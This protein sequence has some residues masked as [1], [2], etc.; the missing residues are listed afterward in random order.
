MGA[1]GQ[2]P[3]QQQAQFLGFAAG[4]EDAPDLEQQRPLA[5]GAVLGGFEQTGIQG[6]AQAGALRRQRIL[7]L[8]AGGLA[9]G[10]LG[11]GITGE[12]V[13]HHFLSAQPGQCALETAPR[14]ADG[15]R[16]VVVGVGA[17]GGQRFGQLGV[18]VQAGDF[19][20]QILPDH[21][22]HPPARRRDAQGVAFLLNFRAQPRQDV[23]HLAGVDVH[24]QQTAHL[25][26]GHLHVGGQFRRAHR[27]QAAFCCAAAVFDQ[28]LGH[29]VG[30]TGREQRIDAALVAVDRVGLEAQPGGGAPQQHRVEVG[31]FD[32]DFRG[33]RPHMPVIAAHDAR[34]AQHAA[35]C[36]GRLGGL[37]GVGH[38]HDLA[39]TSVQNQQV[40]GADLMLAAHQ[41]FDILALPQAERHQNPVVG[42]VAAVIQGRRLTEFQHHVIAAVHDQVNR[43]HPGQ[44]Q[45]ALYLQGRGAVV[46]AADGA[47]REVIGAEAQ[48]FAGVALQRHGA[49]WQRHLDL[50]FAT[51]GQA[52]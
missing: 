31:R 21:H 44:S 7:Q 14:R 20:G 36:L 49:G 6:G 28:Q 25:F 48:L 9:A 8:D 43:A 18:A 13:G 12:G 30:S 26:A 38:A 17:E 50:A 47:G 32:D 37:E 35:V 16:T 24:T 10:L 23:H 1:G 29:P 2:R 15:S 33:V 39:L 34:D 4:R 22:I 41:I 3:A 11:F 46:H 27:R 45:T 40:F 51:G 52:H 42:H 19:L 5:F